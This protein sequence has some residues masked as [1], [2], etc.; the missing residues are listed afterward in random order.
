[1][2]HEKDNGVQRTLGFLD[3]ARRWRGCWFPG[4]TSKWRW[5]WILP[6]APWFWEPGK[7]ENKQSSQ[8][9]RDSRNCHGDKRFKIQI[10]GWKS[11]VCSYS[12]TCIY[13]QVLQLVF[14]I[15][16]QSE[17]APHVSTQ[18]TYTHPSY[19]W[20][21]PNSIQTQAENPSKDEWRQRVE[22]WLLG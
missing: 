4:A 17:R 2:G 10:S 9:A 7:D 5:N 13:Q 1:M 8:S 19:P 6:S 3:G 12:W 18:Q 16:H 20:T 11:L 15:K 14:F 22:G 21:V